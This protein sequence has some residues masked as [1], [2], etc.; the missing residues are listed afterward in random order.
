MEV[1]RLR[2]LGSRVDHPRR[3]LVGHRVA[4]MLMELRRA[5]R[6]VQS[7]PFRVLPV[8]V[9]AVTLLLLVL[10]LLFHELLG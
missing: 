9:V 7:H 10:L 5:V 8:I 3:L 4:L 2:R 6:S 1:R